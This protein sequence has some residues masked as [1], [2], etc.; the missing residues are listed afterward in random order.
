M[1]ND[2][3]ASGP[4]PIRGK[5][6]PRWALGLVVALSCTWTGVAADPVLRVPA[7]ERWIHLAL[8]APP[9]V[10]D[11]NESRW[12]LKEE[13][14]GTAAIPVSVVPA[15]TRNGTPSPNQRQVMASIPP[16]PDAPEVRRFRLQPATAEA[17]SRFQFAE[18][19]GRTLTV[20]EGSRPVMGYNFG[21]LLK[22]GVPADR[23]RSTYVHPLYGVDGELLTDDFPK[24]HYHHRGLFWAWPHVRVAGKD[25]DVWTIKGMHQRFEKWLARETTVAGAVLGVENGWYAGNQKVMQER[26][27]L[28]LYPTANDERVLDVE[29]VL[30]PVDR[31]VTLAGAEGKSYGGL[32]L[33]F[34]PNTGTV[35]TTPLGIS[36][37]D[38]AMT[39]LAWADLT[40]QFKGPPQPGG[41]AIFIAPD[42]P[43]YPPMWL[44]RHYGVLC[45][46]WPGVDAREFPSGEPIRCRYR[47]WIHR[48][49]ADQPGLEKAYAAYLSGE[50]ASWE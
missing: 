1:V 39:R 12:Q 25:Y 6:A 29:L 7:S 24:D 22:P 36:G 17:R 5:V 16:R 43:D 45:V 10:S 2:H 34:A 8:A 19:A 38:L 21:V 44:T 23:A 11:E 33:R 3:S 40:G 50:K 42:H 49:A 27:W 47:V 26:V 35:I 15:T 37:K 13:G 18:E 41:A 31:P 48:G 14:G 32:T 9:S 4:H 20:Q 46:G 28:R 30:V